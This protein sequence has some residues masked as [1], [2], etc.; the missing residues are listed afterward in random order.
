MQYD[1]YISTTFFIYHIIVFIFICIIS[2]R[3]ICIIYKSSGIKFTLVSAT[4][5]YVKNYILIAYERKILNKREC[6]EAY[7]ILNPKRT[8]D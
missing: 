7:E 5:K 4:E 6:F 1:G 2:F 8:L 3:A